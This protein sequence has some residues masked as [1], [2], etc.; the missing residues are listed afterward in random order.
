M[1]LLRIN[2]GC[3]MTPTKEWLNFDNSFSLKLSRFS[4]VIKLL[5]FFRLIN[6]RQ[7]KYIEF[8]KKNKILF[9]NATKKIPLENESVEILYSSHMIEH[10]AKTQVN[11]FLQEVHR[12]MHKNGVFRLI[13]PDF[14]S[15]IN[16]YTIH[17]NID[18][19]LIKSFLV[20]PPLDS[21]KAKL[22]I[23]INGYRHHQWMYS[24]SS[25]KNVLELNNFKNIIFLKDSETT[26]KNV[27]NLNLLER[28]E[29]SIILEC[30]KI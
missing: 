22:Q 16:H 14:D 15:Q 26:I 12:V 6:D 8:C 30:Q 18:E 25:I 3:G 21:F 19:F 10:I 1:K 27:N 5:F 7:K 24:K 29:G 17:K 20:P 28:S 4:F 13:L 9:A 23:L 2:I 11:K